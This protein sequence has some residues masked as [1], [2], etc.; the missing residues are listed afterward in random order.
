[1]RILAK[2]FDAHKKQVSEFYLNNASSDIDPLCGIE[3]C[4]NTLGWS[5]PYCDTHLRKMFGVEVRPSKIHGMGL[6]ACRPFRPRAK[7]LYFSGEVVES[8]HAL[9]RRYSSSGDSDCIA[10]YTIQLRGEYVDALRL[11]H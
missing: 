11:R 7:I 3:A 2:V 9:D 10:L 1:M 5:H 8:L 6:F 4:R